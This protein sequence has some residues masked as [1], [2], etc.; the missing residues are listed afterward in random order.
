M[1]MASRPTP[2][3]ENR[4]L[5]SRPDVTVPA[6][7]EIPIPSSS[8]VQLLAVSLAVFRTFMDKIHGSV[9]LDARGFNQTV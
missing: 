4:V 6:I 2:L 7:F 5:G 9:S 3:L 8:D 1:G